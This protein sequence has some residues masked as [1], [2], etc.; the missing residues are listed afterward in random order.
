V[1]WAVLALL[2]VWLVRLRRR[3]DAVRRARLDEG[4]TVPEDEGPNA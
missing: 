3:R 1:F 2:L 4:W